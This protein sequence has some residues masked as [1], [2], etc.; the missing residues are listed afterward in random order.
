MTKNARIGTV[1]LGACA[2]FCGSTLKVWAQP[3]TAQNA[4]S[5]IGLVD[6]Q[7]VRVDSDGNR[8]V[9]YQLPLQENLNVFGEKFGARRMREYGSL[10]VDE[11][12]GKWLL[13][14]RSDPSGAWQLLIGDSTGNV[15]VTAGDPSCSYN[16]KI[17]DCRIHPKAFSPDGQYFFLETE[18]LGSASLSR[19]RSD[20]SELT[21][22]AGPKIAN[23]LTLDFENQR[24]IYQTTAGLHITAWR[25]SDPT[26]AATKP[27]YKFKIKK[28]IVGPGPIVDG[29][30]ILFRDSDDNLRSYSMR[31]KTSVALA[32]SFGAALQFQTTTSFLTLNSKLEA[33]PSEPIDGKTLPSADRIVTFSVR[34][35]DDSVRL[36]AKFTALN[37][38]SEDRTFALVTRHGSDDLFILD[39]RLGTERLFIKGFGNPYGSVKNP[40]TVVCLGTDS[41]GGDAKGRWPYAQC[42]NAAQFVRTPATK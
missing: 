22:I 2:V 5:V 34:T 40:A 16:P 36:A 1:V 42:G 26:I 20:G 11:R 35:K 14:E 25:V 31:G 9:L 32:G 19:L 15:K 39:E 6:D 37:D 21:R 17:S 13:P 12:S 30:N 3:A 29:D 38:M 4:M 10:L 28:P 23:L 33:T 18:R 41:V 27:V 8:Q 7:L 24:A